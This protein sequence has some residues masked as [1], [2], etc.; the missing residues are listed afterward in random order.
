MKKMTYLLLAVLLTGL[1]SSCKKGEDDPFL[2]LRSRKARVAG[3]WTVSA[4]TIKEVETDDLSSVNRTMTFNGSLISTVTTTTING[5]TTS[6]TETT[7][8]TQKYTFEKDGT[9]TRTDTYEDGVYTTKGTWSFVGKSKENELKN[10]E[11]I[12][13]TETSYT[14]DG[15]TGNYTGFDG[16]ILVIQQL[17]NKEMIFTTAFSSTDADESQ[18]SE[19]SFTLTQN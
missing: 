8:F 9:Y 5:S 12:L 18:S 11:A 10:K 16:T 7:A 3:E 15:E 13:L 19:S 4:A 6:Q 17:K 14:A 2:S 1:V